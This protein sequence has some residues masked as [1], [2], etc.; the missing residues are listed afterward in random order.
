MKK[1]EIEI[2]VSDI[3][4]FSLGDGPGI[5]TTVFFKGCNLLCPWCHNP[6]TQSFFPQ[7]L[8]YAARKE[9]REC[10]K[11]M[12]AAKVLEEVLLDAEFYAASGGGAT[13]SG[14]EPLCQPDGAAAL[15]EMLKRSGVHVLIDTA[16]NVPF[17]AFE[18]IAPFADEYYFD[19]KACNERD[20]ASLGGDYNLIFSNLQRLAAEGKNLTARVPL[21][22]GFNSGDE[23]SAEMCECLRKA[24]VKKVGLLPFHRLG[25]G[26]YAALG[27]EYAYRS[28]P[29]MTVKEAESAAKIYKKYFD[30]YIEQ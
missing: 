29:P 7:I 15:A 26:K 10:G 11:V 24:G 21:I 9:D 2:T 8:H 23:Y 18:K 19:W 22:P 4:H 17:S 1:E 28:C 20:Y 6:E 30:V 16:G 13:L 27:R 5:R 25:S 3:Q 12:P 14:G